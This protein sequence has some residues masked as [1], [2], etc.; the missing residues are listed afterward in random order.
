MISDRFGNQFLESADIAELIYSDR[1]VEPI[2]AVSDL[3]VDLFNG[4]C[5]EVDEQY[6]QIKIVTSS[7]LTS[8]KEYD[9]IKQ[10]IWFM[11]VEYKELDIHAFLIDAAPGDVERR[12]VEYELERF[13]QR[14]LLD[15]LRYL[16]YLTVTMRANKIVWGVGRGSSLSSYC[17]FL[18]GIHKVDSIR[19][20][21]DF[22]EFLKP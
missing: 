1:Y 10:A 16:V 20:C 19:Y 7:T 12:R 4:Q 14:N 13:E 3:Q 8:V 22:D 17:L 6:D 2:A 5:K 11:P 21:L 9:K 18:I 15:L